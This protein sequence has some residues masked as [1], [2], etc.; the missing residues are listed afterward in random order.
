[1]CRKGSV[2]ESKFPSQARASLGVFVFRYCVEWGVLTGTLLHESLP[3]YFALKERGAFKGAGGG[4]QRDFLKGPSQ[5]DLDAAAKLLAVNSLPMPQQ[6]TT[7]AAEF[8]SNRKGFKPPPGVFS[9]QTKTRPAA[10]KKET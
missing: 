1:M 6:R 5:A 7:P 10:V 3:K 4:L 9:L 8:P 2:S